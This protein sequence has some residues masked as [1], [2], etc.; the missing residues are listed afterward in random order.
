MAIL[1]QAY[2]DR[3][4]ALPP[5]PPCEM[6]AYPM[7][8]SGRAAKDLL[9]VFGTRGPSPRLSSGVCILEADCPPQS[10][11]TKPC[12]VIGGTSSSAPSRKP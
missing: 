9:P 5:V 4:Q 10:I 6:L 12:A 7:E 8:A 11:S 3:K 1:I 2:E